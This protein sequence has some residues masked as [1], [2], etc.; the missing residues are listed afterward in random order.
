MTLPF[1]QRRDR[2]LYADKSGNETVFDGP[3]EPEEE[4]STGTLVTDYYYHNFD[5][6]SDQSG[7]IKVEISMDGHVWIP[8]N[9]YSHNGSSETYNNGTFGIKRIFLIV[10][11]L[12]GN[13]IRFTYVNGSTLASRVVISSYQSGN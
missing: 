2:T 9:T 13:F 4:Y 6:M 10:H 12:V 11:Q 1:G 5:V 3:M 7:S 8:Y